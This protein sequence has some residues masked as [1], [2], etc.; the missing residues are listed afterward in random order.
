MVS[1]EPQVEYVYIPDAD[2]KHFRTKIQKMKEF[3]PS[4]NG[5]DIICKFK[6]SCDDLKDKIGSDL[7]LKVHIYDPI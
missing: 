3:S 1:I 2:F 4:C 6:Q 7:D 5:K